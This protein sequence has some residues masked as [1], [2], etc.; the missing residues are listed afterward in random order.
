MAWTKVLQHGLGNLNVIVD[1]YAMPSMES[2]STEVTIVVAS[3]NMVVVT[4]PHQGVYRAVV[5]DG[6]TKYVEDFTAPE[7]PEHNHTMLDPEPVSGCP[8]CDVILVRDDG[9]KDFGPSHTLTIVFPVGGP[10]YEPIEHTIDLRRYNRMTTKPVNLVDALRRFSEIMDETAIVEG[11]MHLLRL[12][13]SKIHEEAGEVEEALIAY[14]GSNP[15]KAHRAGSR[16]A[17]YDLE[18][19]LLQVA[20]AALCAYEHVTKNSG[21]ALRALE[22]ESL[23]VLERVERALAGR[24]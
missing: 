13:C 11:R 1:V 22:A 18:Q 8:G 3:D 24:A 14:E 2:V 20:H 5:T 19:E 7:V 17:Q 10:D 4:V 12:R 21:T 16:D 9:V 6:E 23:R 15:R